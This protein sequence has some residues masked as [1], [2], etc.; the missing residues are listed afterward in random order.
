MQENLEELETTIK[1]IKQLGKGEDL[2]LSEAK[3]L[4][5]LISN[6]AN[7][8]ILLNRFDRQDLDTEGLNPNITYDI[9]YH[10]AVSAV[11]ELKRLLIAKNEARNFSAIKKTRVLPELWE[12][13]SRLSEENIFIR[14]SKSKPLICFISLS[15]IILLQ[16]EINELAHFCLSGF[17]RKTSIVLTGKANLKL[18]KML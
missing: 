9:E 11:N 15:K 13:S 14:A 17:W 2:K 12:V 18:A 16:M 6:Y 7:S 10:E 1:A 5:E 3:G 4:L 8:F